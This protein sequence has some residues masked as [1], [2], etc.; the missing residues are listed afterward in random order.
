MG[1]FKIKSKM[2]ISQILIFAL[3]DAKRTPESH[4]AAVMDDVTEN[5][6]KFSGAFKKKALFNKKKQQYKKVGESIGTLLES[7]GEA[8]AARETSTEEEVT[9][10][11]SGA[12]AI[13]RKLNIVM[14][15][16]LSSCE[17][18]DAKVIAREKKRLDNWHM[19]LKRAAKCGKK[20]A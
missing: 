10:L 12:R 16:Y 2:K 6:A 17:G 8:T 7:C 13:H 5:L 15:S 20:S 14:D 1:S 18:K 11:C 9:D 19:K 4:L 3:V